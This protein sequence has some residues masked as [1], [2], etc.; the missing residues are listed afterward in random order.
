MP[1][2]RKTTATRSLPPAPDD[3]VCQHTDVEGRRCRMLLA[4]GHS[5]LC[6]YHWRR[7]EQ[8][9]LAAQVGAEILGVFGELRTATA[10]NHALARL[11]AALAQNRIPVRRAAVLGYLAQL[12]QHGLHSVKHETQ[13]AI[14]PNAWHDSVRRAF[15]A[16]EESAEVSGRDTLAVLDSPP[17]E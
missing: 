13:V 2:K 1:T 3:G 17:E 12:L 5:H 10:V 4:E 14:G 16:A 7:E 15:E 6:L 9:A 8:D 11:F